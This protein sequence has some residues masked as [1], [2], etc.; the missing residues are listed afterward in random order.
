MLAVGSFLA[1]CVAGHV[2][3]QPCYAATAPPL[4]TAAPAHGQHR[5]NPVL[6]SCLACCISCRRLQL[7]RARLRRLLPCCLP[8]R[9][10]Q[11]RSAR[12]RRTRRMRLKSTLQHRRL[13][14]VVTVPA[15]QLM[16]ACCRHAL[17][18]AYS[19]H[20]PV[21][22]NSS[23]LCQGLASLCANVMHARLHAG[24]CRVPV[25]VLH[26]QAASILLCTAAHSGAKPRA[27]VLMC[28]TLLCSP[29]PAGAAAHLLLPVAAVPPAAG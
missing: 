15:L 22:P 6:L 4:S 18:Q 26:G 24:K 23:S 17:L 9:S 12:S 28:Q 13:W 8:K 14:W 3:L 25:C 21:A 27:A 20:T 19:V 2:V 10:Q 29:C 5:T 11:R 7:P 1:A 16:P